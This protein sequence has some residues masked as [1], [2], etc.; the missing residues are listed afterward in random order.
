MHS[1]Y[2]ESEVVV[3]YNNH[4]QIKAM[5]MRCSYESISGQGHSSSDIIG[6][7]NHDMT[8]CIG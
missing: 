1:Y 3:V 6:K 4:A 8:I 7:E 5:D 2:R